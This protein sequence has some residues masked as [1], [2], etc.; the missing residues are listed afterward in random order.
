M[1]HDT[2]Q[3]WKEVQDIVSQKR[4]TPRN[5]QATQA[6]QTVQALR[7]A[8]NIKYQQSAHTDRAADYTNNTHKSHILF[9]NEPHK[10]STDLQYN[11][12]WRYTKLLDAALVIP[13][14][15][16]TKQLINHCHGTSF[17]PDVLTTDEVRNRAIRFR[18]T[19]SVLHVFIRGIRNQSQAQT[20]NPFTADLSPIKSRQTIVIHTNPN[21]TKQSLHVPAH[22]PN[23]DGNQG[24]G[25]DDSNDGDDSKDNNHSAHSIN[26][27]FGNQR[28]QHIQNGS[29]N[30]EYNN[31]NHRRDRNQNQRRNNNDDYGRDGDENDAKYGYNNGIYHRLPITAYPPQSH[32]YSTKN[33]NKKR[34]CFVCDNDDHWTVQCDSTYEKKQCGF[35]DNCAFVHQSDWTHDVTLEAIQD[36]LKRNPRTQTWRIKKQYLQRRI[37][38]QN[39]K[40]SDIETPASDSFDINS[41]DFDSCGSDY[42]IDYDSCDIDSIYSDTTCGADSD[43]QDMYLPQHLMNTDICSDPVINETHTNQTS[44][45]ATTNQKKCTTKIGLKHNCIGQQA[46]VQNKKNKNDDVGIVFSNG[47]LKPNRAHRLHRPIISDSKRFGRMAGDLFSLHQLDE[48]QFDVSRKLNKSQPLNFNG[49]IGSQLKRQNVIKHS[50]R[51]INAT[52]SITMNQSSMVMSL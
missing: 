30:N 44:S 29:N 6:F 35:K 26:L 9:K 27:Q 52:T 47:I 31:N 5:T 1:S 13:Y 21:Q 20:Q 33:K 48:G 39:D 19:D 24:N 38:L 14:K 50:D 2:I 16:D 15:L 40:E 51:L 8:S 23:G 32:H 41:F 37:H 7:S 10:P 11:P 25:R 12:K 18:N 34:H 43:E 22:V 28:E 42:T 46:A 4:E 3:S 36:E 45:S 49:S 17:D